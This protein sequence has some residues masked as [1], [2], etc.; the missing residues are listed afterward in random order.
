VQGGEE[1]ADYGQALIR[2]LSQV[3]TERYGR[4]FSVTNLKYVRLFC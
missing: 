3:L 4:G 2:G 1:R